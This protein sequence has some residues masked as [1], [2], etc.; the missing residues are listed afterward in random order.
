MEEVV[1]SID[2]CPSCGHSDYR[3]TGNRKSEDTSLVNLECLRCGQNYDLAGSL[4]EA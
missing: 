1:M 4:V 3:K 2:S